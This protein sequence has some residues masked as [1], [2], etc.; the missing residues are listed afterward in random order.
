MKQ[1]VMQNAREAAQTKLFTDIREIVRTKILLPD[2]DISLN[3]LVRTW[4]LVVVETANRRYVK[5]EVVLYYADGQLGTEF[6][7]LKIRNKK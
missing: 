5:L 3:S 6:A 1:V 2:A 4:F 7:T